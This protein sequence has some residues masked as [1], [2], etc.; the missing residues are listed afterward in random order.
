[1]TEMPEYEDLTLSQAAEILKMRPKTL[2]KRLLAGDEIPGA[3]RVGKGWRFHR[4][5][6]HLRL[7]LDQWR[8]MKQ[9]QENPQDE[10]AADD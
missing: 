3:Y 5:A 4:A 2:Y 6:F 10:L 7:T 8:T 9:N 1:M